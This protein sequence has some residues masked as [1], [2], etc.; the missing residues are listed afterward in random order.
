M[1]TNNYQFLLLISKKR[2]EYWVGYSWAL[3]FIG[4]LWIWINIMGNS[5]PFYSYGIKGSSKLFNSY[6]ANILFQNYYSLKM[7]IDSSLLWILMIPHKHKII[8]KVYE[9]GKMKSLILYH[10]ASLNTT[11]FHFALYVRNTTPIQHGCTLKWYIM[12]S[13]RYIISMPLN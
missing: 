2:I 11:R 9:N 3:T 8:P 5:F 12:F 6:S 7:L 10:S 4:M 1:C 13:S